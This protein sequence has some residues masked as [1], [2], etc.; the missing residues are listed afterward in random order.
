M[1]YESAFSRYRRTADDK[2]IPWREAND[3]AARIGGW[4]AYARDAQQP[5][6]AASA[7]AATPAQPATKA[8]P[9]P[10]GHGGH[11]MP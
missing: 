1:A 9:M 2:V 7:P 6:P 4:R 10:Q 11:K 8:M 5:D 3:T